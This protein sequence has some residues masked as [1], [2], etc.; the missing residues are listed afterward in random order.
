MP[1]RKQHIGIVKIRNLFR[2]HGGILRTRDIL[3]TWNPS[4]NPVQMRETGDL[5]Q[6]TRGLYRLSGLPKLS[7]QT[8]FQCH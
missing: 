7:N 1:V 8:L 3:A 4:T 5:E 6:L 2:R